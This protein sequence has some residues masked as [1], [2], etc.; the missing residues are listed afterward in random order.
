MA[1]I[2]N[3][4]WL[5]IGGIA[6]IITPIF[7]W[8]LS[9]IPQFQ[10]TFSTLALDIRSQVTGVSGMNLS[11][12]LLG[13]I[14]QDFSLP[15]LAVTIIGGAL[16][17]LLARYLLDYVVK[18]IP[19]KLNTKVKILVAVFIIASIVEAFI[20]SSGLPSLS[21]AL[22]FVINAVAMAYVVDYVLKGMGM[23]VG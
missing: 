5:M 3:R 23:K 20:V 7:M 8:V 22:G 2:N 21:I 12:F 13:I 6:S 9:L 4:N 10:V 15:A 19:F 14:G 18:V 1:K 16:I 11:N 17:V